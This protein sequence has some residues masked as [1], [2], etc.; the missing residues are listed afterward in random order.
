MKKMMTLAVMMTIA[1]SA[2]AMTYNE[3]RSEALFLSDK[4]AY[5]LDLTEEQYEAVYEINLDY[6][7]SVNSRYDINGPWWDRRNA[8]LRHVLAAWQYDRFLRLNYFYRPVSWHAGAWV[9]HIHN[10]YANRA[11]FYRPRPAVFLSYRGGYNRMHAGYYAGR[12]IHRPAVAPGQ[13]YGHGPAI[14]HGHGPAHNGHG[15]VGHNG[16]GSVG[17][18]GHGPTHNSH[19]HGAIGSSHG[20]GNGSAHNSSHNR[21]SPRRR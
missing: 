11:F 20:H 21:P 1:I 12:N 8:D 9:F 16:H 7:M 15:S 5:E 2:A 13:H 6:L 10:L 3:A 14:H 19:N 18:N 17:H 4:M